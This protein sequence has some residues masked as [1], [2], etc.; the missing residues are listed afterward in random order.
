ME[1]LNFE[2]HKCVLCHNAPCSQKCKK[3]D[4]EKIIRAARFENIKGARMLI[5]NENP[6]IDCDEPCKNVCPA[7]VDIKEI[8]SIIS[9]EDK[10]DKE[11]EV[12]I[13]TEICDVK[14]ENPFLLS[15]SVVGSTY[16]M[17][18]RAFEA[19]WAGVSFKTISLMQMHEAS[20]RF[21]VLKEWDNSFNG[22]KNIE[23]LSEKT[24]DE[25][26][27]IFKRLKKDFPE[28]VLIVSIMGRNEEEWEYLSKKVSEAGADVIELNFSCP[29]MEEKGTGSDVGQNPEYVEKYTR[30][31][32]KGTNKPILAKMTPNITDIRIPARAAIR[33][34]A[35]GISAINTIKSITG[36]E[37]DTLV[38]EPNVNGK[39]AVGGY[40]GRAVKPIALRFISDLAND[41]E[42]EGICISGMGGIYTWKDA[43]EFLSLGAQT[44]QMTTSIMEYGYR[45][46][47]DL[48][49]GLK[50]YISENNFKSIKELIG[51]SRIKVVDSDDIERNTIEFPKFDYE[52]CI[53]CGRCYISCMDGG[54]QAIKFDEEKRIPKLDGSKCVGCQLCRLVCPQ[55]A[56]GKATKRIK[57]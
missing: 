48:L 38:P 36:V 18:K 39:C 32:R 2:L 22:F 19:G 34:G 23:Q 1:K 14:L 54:H 24:V 10:I 29:N 15:S 40:S 16:D 17:C 27:S 47:D 33:G 20:P 41:K 45:I 52:K 21:S 43:V 57:K 13:T 50:I 25:N 31:A 5:E 49:M 28:K 7:N 26:I 46:I 44:L 8:V 35:D 3:C 12:D 53:G 30:A 6:C 11:I 51:I 56:I 55:N 37:I 4:P 9:K 42:I